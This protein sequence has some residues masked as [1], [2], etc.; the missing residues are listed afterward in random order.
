[1]GFILFNVFSYI[2]YYVFDY[3]FN[4]FNLYSKPNVGFM[5]LTSSDIKL[6]IV[7]SIISMII[8]YIGV[9]YYNKLKK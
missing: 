8:A 5:D 7:N 4:F 1:M 2:S 3:L 9:D 6:V